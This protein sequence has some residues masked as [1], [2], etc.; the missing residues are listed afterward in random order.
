M[1]LGGTDRAREIFT[2]GFEFFGQEEE[3][4]DKS[5]SLYS[6]FAKMEVRHKEYDRA[7]VIYKVRRLAFQPPTQS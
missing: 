2:M 7:R 3:G 4:V 6:A 1:V 5:Q